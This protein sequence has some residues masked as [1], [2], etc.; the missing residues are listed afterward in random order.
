MHNSDGC[1]LDWLLHTLT[2]KDIPKRRKRRVRDILELN[3][4]EKSL[5]TFFV[6]LGYSGHIVELFGIISHT[7]INTHD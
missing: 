4:V 1:M 7:V 5:S 2:Q 3:T 6:K